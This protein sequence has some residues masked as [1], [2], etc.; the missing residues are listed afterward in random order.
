MPFGGLGGLGGMGGMNGMNGLNGI[1]GLGGAGGIGGS[2]G[3]GGMGGMPD[4]SGLGGM[5]GP[6]GDSGEAVEIDPAKVEEIRRLVAN[7]PALT[8]PLVA[9]IKEQEPVLAA[10]LTEDPESI[11]R[12]FSQDADDSGRSGG[13]NLPLSVTA[14][15]SAARPAP[16]A[17]QGGLTLA[18]E[19]SINRVRFR[20]P[21]QPQG[22]P[23]T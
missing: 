13:G 4:L 17:V 15:V 9:H 8:R 2:G 11:L 6:N 1:G 12:F 19:A 20:F 23:L 5:G 14:A 18:D 10:G 22:Q 7:N 21:Y 16:P 3:M